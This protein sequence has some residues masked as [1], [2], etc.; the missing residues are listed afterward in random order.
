MKCI[1]CGKDIEL[2]DKTKPHKYCSDYCRNRARGIRTGKYGKNGTMTKIC[3]ICGKEFETTISH[4][5]T[6]SN[7]CSRKR[8][9]ARFRYASPEQKA[10]RKEYDR[11][12]YLQKHPDALTQEERSELARVKRELE[13]PDRERR[14]QEYE[15]QKEEWAKKRAEKEKQKQANIKYWQ[16]YESE[17]ECVICGS[18]YI[19]HYPL[20][21]YCSKKC[22]RKNVRI[23]DTRRRYK[24]ITV[25]KG[26][27]LPKLVKRDHNQC[28]ICGLFVDWNDYIETDKTIICGNMYPSIDHIRPISKG[29]LHSWD[30]VQLAHRI[31]NTRKNNEYTG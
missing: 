21:K 31:C 4:K 6:C 24:N 23:R 15:R 1:C 16:E 2:T 7:E 12:K 10:K 28:Q 11:Q 19:A 3:A 30:N 27:T 17:H 25:D 13:T 9:N 29:G 18:K 20:S 22:A 8:R 26:I 14:K 5:I